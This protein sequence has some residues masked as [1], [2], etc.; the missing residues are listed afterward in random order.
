VYDSF[1]EPATA[2][3][4]RI[5][6]DQTT[7]RPNFR[8][9]EKTIRIRWMPLCEVET[10]PLRYAADLRYQ[11]EKMR[12]G[13][14]R[15]DLSRLVARE[16]MVL[17]CWR[18]QKHENEIHSAV[19]RVTNP[20]WLSRSAAID[21]L[22]KTDGLRAADGRLCSRRRMHDSA[23]RSSYSGGMAR[24]SVAGVLPCCASNPR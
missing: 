1:P 18:S 11:F 16:S 22:V 2:N 5:N 9:L 20:R 15:L 17:D 6:V 14:T 12:I 4:P 13:N 19:N 21:R 3:R 7:Q 8:E 24:P 10:T 23:I